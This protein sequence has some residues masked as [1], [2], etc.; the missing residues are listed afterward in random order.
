MDRSLMNKL[1][2]ANLRSGRDITISV[3]GV[4]MNPTLYD[5]DRVTV[6]RADHY[7]IGDILVFFYKGELLIHRLI[8]KENERYFCKG[9]N[10]FR[11]EDLTIDDIFGK[12]ILQNQ[13]PI[14]ESPKWLPE[15]SYL[16]NRTFRKCGY[17]IEKTKKSGIYRFYYKTIM[18]AED[19]TMIY[20]K[21][22]NMDYIPADETSMAIFDPESR[23]THFLNETGVDIINCLEPP[24]DIDTLL[25]RLCKIY[26]VTP[27]LIRN[28]VE[29]FINEMV[30]KK[31][32]I[33]E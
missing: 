16:V 24:C 21:N 33:P 22:E 1:L 5:G 23:N 3:T 20:K 17:D 19:S 12:V 8:K 18:K 30:A 14:I 10:A 29:E 6:L 7:D 27:E 2:S 9:D 31:V 15:L 13:Q 11:L 32:I 4:S 26:D 25:D 28:D